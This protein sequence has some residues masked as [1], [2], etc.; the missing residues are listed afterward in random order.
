GVLMDKEKILSLFPVFLQHFL[1]TFFNVRQYKLRRGGYYNS[2]RKYFRNID[3][4]TEEQWSI[5]QEKRLKEFLNYV[6]QKSPW[7]KKH[8]A[9]K[10]EDFPILSKDD[11]KNNFDYIKTLA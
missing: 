7:Y 1:V 2:F 4:M 3:N 6:T 8:K 11:I 5:E 10:L 9:K